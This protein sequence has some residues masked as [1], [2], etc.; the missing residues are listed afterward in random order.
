MNYDRKTL[1]LSALAMVVILLGGLAVT[2]VILDSGPDKTAKVDV[3]DSSGAKPVSIPQPNSGTAPKTA[4]D[5]GGWEQLTVFGLML[6]AMLGIGVV[7][8]HGGKSAV[9][10]HNILGGAT[11][12]ASDDGAR[13]Y[14]PDTFDKGTS[15][16]DL[17]MAAPDARVGELPNRPLVSIPGA[18]ASTF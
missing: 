5:R 11:Y 12:A 6:G 2:T 1:W 8:F 18:F 14:F 3:T 7:V 16:F 9:V 4:G 17:V 13:V 10:A 15:S